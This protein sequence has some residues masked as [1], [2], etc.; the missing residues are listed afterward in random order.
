MCRKQLRDFFD[1]GVL[2]ETVMQI[3]EMFMSMGSPH[4]WVD[5][6]MPADARLYKLAT[7]SSHESTTLPDVTKFDQLMEETRA[8]LL[9]YVHHIGLGKCRYYIHI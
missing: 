5:F 1:T 3:L 8:V 4:Q 6:L 7:A 2:H 9:R